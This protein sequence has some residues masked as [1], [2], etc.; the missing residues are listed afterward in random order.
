MQ[1][2]KL[3]YNSPAGDDWNSALPIGCGRLG[4]MV[5][6]NVDTERIQTNEDSVWSG[7]PRDRTNPDALANLGEIRRLLLAGDPVAAEQLAQD[8]LC[9]VPDIMRHYEPLCDLLLTFY[10]GENSDKPIDNY[11]R[12]L[13][14]DDSICRVSYARGNTQYIRE[15]ICSFPDQV[16]AIRLTASRSGA[17]SFR[18]R[19]QRGPFDN[20][21]ARYAE[22]ICKNDDNSLLMI[23][24]TTG[25]AISFSAI[26]NVKCE[27]GTHRIVGETLIVEN[28]DAVTLLFAAATS[29]RENTSSLA[30]VK[31]IEDCKHLTWNELKKRHIADYKSLFNLVTLNLGFNPTTEN[32]DTD[33][34]LDFI[35]HGGSDP[36]LISLYFQYGRYLL[37]SSSRPGSLPANLQGIWNQEFTPPWGS[38][39]TININ[40]EMNYWPAETCNLAECHEPLF[41]M[42][43]R[44]QEPGR[45]MA[46]DMY[47]CDGVVCHHNTDLWDDTAPVD[48]NVASTYWPMG[49]AW[50]TLHLWEGYQFMPDSAFLDRIY[51]ALKNSSLFFKDFLI[52]DNQGRLITC[53][54]S[55]PE[56]TYILPNGNKGQLCAGSTMDTAI[57]DQ[58]FRATIEAAEKLNVDADLQQ[59][60]E[61]MRQQLPQFKIGQFGQLQEWPEDYEEAEPGHRH[62]SH[63]Y[64]LH[65]GDQI[66]PSLTPALAAAARISLE[67]RLAAGG[68]HTG[69]SRAWIINFWARL[70]D[71]DKALENIIALLAKSTLPNLFDNHPPFQIDGNFGG[72]AGIAE[73]L[74]QS[75]NGVIH[76]LPALPTAWKDG[77][78]KGLRARGGFE[79]NMTWT[80]GI[81][82]SAVIKSKAGQPCTIKLE[83][84]NN[85]SIAK[86]PDGEYK[87]ITPLKN[88]EW[89]LPATDE[90]IWYIK[91]D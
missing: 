36:G 74:L 13:D 68:G 90:N 88:G 60:L 30:C 39:Y 80:T 63:L 3:W 9:G 83:N 67:R 7:G 44:L 42:V 89:R 47:D 34:R 76:L 29:Y 24:S 49:A 12:E 64:A 65:P 52:E 22:S 6:G 84:I 4:G 31:T 23:G 58:L 51:T 87:S 59:Q 91:V 2:L 41:D 71:G 18:L 82:K 72:T 75:H 54:T 81:L 37:I 14:L 20:Y 70:C 50:L 40:T 38:K 53:P 16:M 26:T 32:S 11:H 79:V 17:I 46:R 25:G 5:F 66:S 33:K 15:H 69:W 85:I 78:V 55:S 73:M 8:A 86:S 1:K 21:A 62:V 19:M 10:H 48:R 43:E 61:S 35:A 77:T 57:I 28:A 27:G 45:K 56:N